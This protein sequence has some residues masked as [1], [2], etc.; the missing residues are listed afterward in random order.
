MVCNGFTN[1]IDGYLAVRRRKY[2]IQIIEYDDLGRLVSNTETL[3]DMIGQSTMILNGDSIYIR[4]CR[5][6][7]LPK[8]FLGGAAEPAPVAMFIEDD[9]FGA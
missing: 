6:I 1:R 2:G 5:S 7:E 8:S 3:G 9:G 4:I